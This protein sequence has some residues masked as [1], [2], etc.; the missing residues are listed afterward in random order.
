MR[1]ITDDNFCGGNLRIVI[2][3]REKV[4]EGCHTFYDP[5]CDRTFKNVRVARCDKEDKFSEK[6][7]IT[8]VKQKLALDYHK[9]YK[10]VNNELVKELTNVIKEL[11][12]SKEFHSKKVESLQSALAKKYGLSFYSGKKRKPKKTEAKK[13]AKTA[14]SSSK[15]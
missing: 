14:K 9:Y 3:D 4:I 2:D 12:Q 6:A 13:G 8:L 5:E 15:K 1:C 10:N 7:G 11:T